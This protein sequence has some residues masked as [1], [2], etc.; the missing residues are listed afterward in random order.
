MCDILRRLSSAALTKQQYLSSLNEFSRLC[1]ARRK[2]EL[3][4]V[5]GRAPAATT[6]NSNHAPLKDVSDKVAKS[7]SEEEEEEEEETAMDESDKLSRLQT[8]GSYNPEKSFTTE[9]KSIETLIAEGPNP[10]FRLNKNDE[11]GFLTM[12][13]VFSW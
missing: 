8:V 9:S 5:V 4:Q 12:D 2:E 1:R 7:K 10:V 13:D 3:F 11:N 6:T